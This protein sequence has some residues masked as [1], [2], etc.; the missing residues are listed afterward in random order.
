MLILS[1]P[2]VRNKR[3]HEGEK[4]SKRRFEKKKK[5]FGELLH[6]VI[7]MK[8]LSLASYVRQLR[9][10]APLPSELL[11]QPVNIEGKPNSFQA[12]P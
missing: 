4:E 7:R 9:S 12:S 2:Q 11:H 3:V 10:L 1:F 5:R 6:N 8:E